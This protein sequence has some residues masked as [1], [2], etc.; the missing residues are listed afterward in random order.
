MGASIQG[1]YRYATY[2]R[3]AHMFYLFA[4][5]TYFLVSRAATEMRSL[6]ML[7][8][9]SNPPSNSPS[10]LV[11]AFA[12]TR[13]IIKAVLS[14]HI[15]PSLLPQHRLIFNI[16]AMPLHIQMRQRA[17]RYS[18][19]NAVKTRDWNRGDWEKYRID[20]EIAAIGVQ[21]NRSRQIQLN[22]SGCSPTCAP[23]RCY[24]LNFLEAAFLFQI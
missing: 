20:R 21:L 11:R 22:K 6:V 15:N 10:V 7:S 17:R 19:L 23:F 8:A 16:V 18:C 12:K 24:V 5:K 3:N 4:C 2:I 13:L 1:V 14:S 9:K